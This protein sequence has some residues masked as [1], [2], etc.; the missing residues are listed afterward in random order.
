MRAA[1]GRLHKGLDLYTGSPSPVFAAADGEIEFA[2]D[3]GDY[4]ETVVIRHGAGVQT[5]YAHL[6]GY[7]RGIRAGAYV[8][9]GE[10]IGETG[11]TG[12]ATAVH[13]H[14]EIIVDGQPE[15]PLTVGY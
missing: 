15:N 5:R 3:L 1:T 8:R 4:G 14:Y 11:R 6:S 7:A 9:A 13:L 10:V 2:G 12:N